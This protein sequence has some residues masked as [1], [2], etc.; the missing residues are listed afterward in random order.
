MGHNL[1]A[2]MKDNI[3]AFKGRGCYH[4]NWNVGIPCHGEGP[5]ASRLQNRH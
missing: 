2:G 1:Q 5:A 4:H 3:T